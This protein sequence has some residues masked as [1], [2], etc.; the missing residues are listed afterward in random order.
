MPKSNIDSPTQILETTTPN[1]IFSVSSYL[2]LPV[3]Y[4]FTIKIKLYQAKLSMFYN[5]QIINVTF[6]CKIWDV[7]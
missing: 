1:M 6:V 3:L 5:I 4:L 2:D 7:Q